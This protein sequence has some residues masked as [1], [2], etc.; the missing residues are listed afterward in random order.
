MCWFP[1]NHFCGPWRDE[2]RD[3]KAKRRA[4]NNRTR[5]LLQLLTRGAA[6]SIMADALIDRLP[7]ETTAA[8]ARRILAL[9]SAHTTHT[10]DRTFH[11]LALLD[12]LPNTA[13]ITEVLN[14]LPQLVGDSED[15][16]SALVDSLK[17]LARNDR[18]LML[19]A[20]GA[21]GETTLPDA[22]K[23]EV[24]KLAYTALPLADEAD[25]P[26]LV[27]VLLGSQVGAAAGRTLRGMREQ[28][29]TVSAG[30]LALLLQVVS[31][32]LHAHGGTAR[33]LLGQTASA[34]HLSTWDATLLL[35][36]LALPRHA[37][38][39]T[40][41][42]SRA[43]RRG[44]L[45]A[46]VLS[47]SAIHEALPPAVGA[48]LPLLV[49]A[50]LAESSADA[51]A[52]GAWLAVTLVVGPSSPAITS[53]FHDAPPP[54]AHAA[55]A[56]APTPAPAP[57]AAPAPAP[58]AATV[59]GGH[60]AV[61]V[62]ALSELIA[63]LFA[64]SAHTAAAAAA[65][66]GQLAERLRVASA[67]AALGGVAWSMLQEAMVHASRLPPRLVPPLCACLAAGA[68]AL[69]TL[70]PPLLIYI[71]KHAF[72]TGGGHAPSCS[73]RHA[74]VAASGGG[75]G[76][77]EEAAVVAALHLAFA[78]LG[79]CG[80]LSP[81]EAASVIQWALQAVPLA[82]GA[83]A[84]LGWRLLSRCVPL[85]AASE[86]TNLR[87]RALPA[88]MRAWGT[89]LPPTAPPP[90]QAGGG[91]AGASSSASG[92]SAEAA[93]APVLAC[94][95]PADAHAAGCVW[96]AAPT[97]AADDD[98][99]AWAAEVVRAQLLCW[100]RLR[101]HEAQHHAP[102]MAT[103]RLVDHDDES[104]P[105]ARVAR[106]GGGGSS[107]SSSRGSKQAIARDTSPPPLPSSMRWRLAIPTRLAAA[108]RAINARVCDEGSGGDYDDDDDD[109]DD[110]EE[111][112]ED[113]QEGEQEAEG[114]E[115]T[116]T[117]TTTSAAPRGGSRS[118]R[119]SMQQA[120]EPTRG[121]YA[122]L[123]RLALRFLSL[124]DLS[125]K[126]HAH[127]L[128]LRRPARDGGSVAASA[129]SAS[130]SSAVSIQTATDGV[131][132]PLGTVSGLMLQLA[133]RCYIVRLIT[134]A[135]S[136]A[137][138]GGDPSCTWLQGQLAA[139]LREP[140]SPRLCA[141]GLAALLTPDAAAASSPPA[142]SDLPL[143]VSSS[144]LRRHLLVELWKDLERRTIR[145]RDL[146]ADAP[147]PS[148][149]AI[150]NSAPGPLTSAPPPP[151]Q[152]ALDPCASSSMG[153]GESEDDG[154]DPSAHSGTLLGDSGAC[155]G[156]YDDGLGSVATA[157][158][159][160]HA[161]PESWL[162]TALPVLVT[163][164]AELAATVDQARR[165][166]RSTDAAWK[167][168]LTTLALTYRS[169]AAC[170]SHATS[171]SSDAGA[172]SVPGLHVDSL[173]RWLSTMHHQLARVPDAH[174]AAALLNAMRR[175]ESLT[176]AASA[177]TAP[178]AS[179]PP[180]PPCA[181]SCVWALTAVFPSHHTP[182]AP[183]LPP[184]AAPAVRISG[185]LTERCL[186]INS[187]VLARLRTAARGQHAAFATLVQM[188]LCALPAEQCLI[189][190]RALL[191]ASDELSAAVVKSAKNAGVPPPDDAE[192]VASGLATGDKATV[193]GKV[194]AV[195][196]AASKGSS[197]APSSHAAIPLLV[198]S[199]RPSL[200]L[201]II[202]NLEAALLSLLP[203]D[204]PSTLRDA[205]DAAT[206]TGA[207]V[208]RALTAIRPLVPAAPKGIGAALCAE[209]AATCAA[210]RAVL[211]DAIAC[212]CQPGCTAA[213]SALSP[214]QGIVEELVS[215]QRTLVHDLKQRPHADARRKKRP[216]PKSA[217]PPAQRGGVRSGR[218]TKRSRG[219][220]G[221]DGDGGGGA[222]AGAG[223]D[224]QGN[225][226]DEGDAD[227]GG[228][229][230]R[231]HGLVLPRWLLRLEELEI[232]LAEMRRMHHVPPPSVADTAGAKAWAAGVGLSS[233]SELGRLRKWAWAAGGGATSRR[234]LTDGDDDHAGE[235]VDDDEEMGSELDMDEDAMLGG[236]AS[237]P[238]TPDD[239]EEEEEDRGGYDDG[240]SS[241][242]DAEDSDA[243]LS[244]AE[245]PNGPR[246]GRGAAANDGAG[247]EARFAARAGIGEDDDGMVGDAFDDA[248]PPLVVDFRPKKRAA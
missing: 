118:A 185:A 181:H 96:L 9:L 187:A 31:S 81:A 20:I 51:P 120:S 88:C 104:E 152:R 87:T 17:D 62:Q 50:L 141:H 127:R 159:G 1:K 43:L 192:E 176:P 188:A 61:R 41:A 168:N 179:S 171:M 49:A 111:E 139:A 167:A 29:G 72:V 140:I 153:A 25:L 217:L 178:A 36:L 174:L 15:E 208:T 214:L 134:H 3:D 238:Q 102:S 211:T 33:A 76:G 149:M 66:L 229:V 169:I 201:I 228:S 83:G 241:A 220:G 163:F 191:Q 53:L 69:P 183:H 145:T 92:A 78:L 218:R 101:D 45:P 173:T 80:A 237:R 131:D 114:I 180:P 224:A 144:E 155:D 157:R 55:A 74:S 170:A 231:G 116:T 35:L 244:G 235:P 129:G 243:A 71:Q 161:P 122:S 240:Y 123:A 223:D 109:D 197:R 227:G 143:S 124:L 177:V 12:T 156:V 24:A 91:V 213:P 2:D 5:P 221:G 84:A 100:F 23:P 248:P 150:E 175:V 99:S 38:S 39:A 184:L 64:E 34:S 93:S 209:C 236:G 136:A 8:G 110:K 28:V 190:L 210:L 86:R 97:L 32:A 65:A 121:A 90:H 82:R 19:P 107:S 206:K 98:S 89:S 198:P 225:G 42:L 22:L 215:V 13:V 63:A 219:A 166:R 132:D 21:L 137:A 246:R 130:S 135:T 242:S 200:L 165:T 54:P 239:D 245:S 151:P 195:G 70:R 59:A 158:A 73:P 172:G 196:K 14:T 113:G 47:A 18:T 56:P 142:D 85:L 202:T 16:K 7:L 212:R 125:L 10:P 164:S 105:M 115:A 247:W 205:L 112:E 162:A 226:G 199:A 26:T 146:G 117:T 194:A 4:T 44:A 6:S 75:G 154:H 234:G 94:G 37:A 11:L 58:A 128:S 233:R 189:C 203:L 60:D 27:R 138:D 40:H 46:S 186:S 67:V 103:S 204:T 230:R 57:A 68:A 48:R 216:A 52:H 232:L 207:L 160:A 182:L 222:D 79:T 119:A 108:E 148:S 30:T 126:W 77:M 95:T 193:V 106:I 147:A 133:D